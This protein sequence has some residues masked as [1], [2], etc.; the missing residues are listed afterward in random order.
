MTNALEEEFNKDLKNYSESHPS[1][2][3]DNKDLAKYVVEKNKPKSRCSLKLSLNC[4]K[5][6][7][8]RH[9]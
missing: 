2:V 5:I 1:F 4:I 7:A 8:L 3:L 6:I 9:T